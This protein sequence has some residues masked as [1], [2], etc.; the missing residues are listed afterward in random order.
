MKVTSLFDSS[1]ETASAAELRDRRRLLPTPC[2]TGVAVDSS[3]SLLDDVPLMVIS[4]FN[5]V[6][7]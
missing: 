7:L 2:S 5:A 1:A 3:Q 4:G 6:L